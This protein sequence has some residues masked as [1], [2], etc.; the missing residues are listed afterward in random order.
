MWLPFTL[1]F[2]YNLFINMYVPVQ[3]VIFD[4]YLYIFIVLMLNRIF[5]SQ[6]WLLNF[7]SLLFLFL[8]LFF[9]FH[10][11]YFLRTRIF[12]LRKFVCNL[13]RKI[14]DSKF[15]IF[16]FSRKCKYIYL[17]KKEC[18]FFIL[19]VLKKINLK[20]FFYDLCVCYF[21]ISKSVN[22]IY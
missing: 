16:H 13:L 8:S 21:Y 17:I 5:V 1:N 18:Y 22:L 4:W 19:I 12:V 10:L 9:F 3:P 6:I 15:Q 14:E 20:Y 11:L 2:V 7:F